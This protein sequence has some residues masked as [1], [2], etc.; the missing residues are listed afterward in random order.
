[1]NILVGAPAEG[2]VLGPAKTRRPVY[3]IVG[4]RV[5]MGVDGEGNSHI[6]R[7]GEGDDGLETRKG[8]DAGY[9]K[10]GAGAP[11]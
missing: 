4:G 1:M 5:V 10:L 6:E 3:R 7:E 8:S 9:R 11:G 2:E